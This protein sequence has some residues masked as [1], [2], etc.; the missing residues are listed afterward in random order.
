MSKN[1]EEVHPAMN[2]ERAELFPLHIP[3][4]GLFK[5]SRGAVGG[6]SNARTVV[7]IKLTDEAGHS[8][9][10]EASP[11]RLWSSETMETVV[12]TLDNYLLPAVI[13]RDADDIAGIHQ[14][15][16]AVIAPAFSSA[17]PIAKCGIDTAVH[18]LLGRRRGMSI[19]KLWGYQ[20]AAEVALSWTV[21]AS[22]MDALER[23]V[24]DGLQHGY[25]NF[26]VKLGMNAAFD[27]MQCN[28]LKEKVP[29]G[30]LWGDAN[31]GY[32]FHEIVR[33][34]P[35]LE[36]SGLDLL[37]QPLPS[38]QLKDLARL[39]SRLR[40]PIGVDEP[41]V[42][43]R[44]LMEWIRHD[45]ITAYVA[46]PTRNSGLFPSRICMEIARHAPLMTVCSG[47]TETGVGL[48]ANLQLACA[49]GV[50]TPC[51]W[52]GPQYLQEDILAQP[53]T[54]KGGK[55]QLPAGAGLG[56]AVDEEKV[57]YLSSVR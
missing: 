51:A 54:I 40:I 7:L 38:N 20:P 27:V 10:G 52:N 4:K 17:H 18:D 21:S 30:F 56:I 28:W 1:R 46:K 22:D 33:I 2:I 49:F 25:R 35:D 13:G 9:W 37:E 44:E 50:T 47:L 45:L 3:M 39:T 57:R 6:K 19:A 8:G 5:T 14:A 55:L 41:I 42:T 29:D 48:A 12:G 11:S 32:A 53:L 31:G 36:S 26:N 23:S 43:P 34:L 24:D 16:N 15:M